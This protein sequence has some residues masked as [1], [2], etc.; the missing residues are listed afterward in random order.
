MRFH[1]PMNMVVTSLT[2]PP[3]IASWHDRMRSLLSTTCTHRPCERH[4][5]KEAGGISAC[6]AAR[7]RAKLHRS[8]GEPSPTP[9]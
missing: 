2:C 3:L 9:P 6:R 1:P 8:I 4:V 5:E 7:A